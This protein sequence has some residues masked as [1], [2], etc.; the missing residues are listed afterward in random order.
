MAQ[1]RDGSSGRG[2]DRERGRGAR[3]RQ[4]APGGSR[5]GRSSAGRAAGSP[6]SRHS[7]RAT[8]RT[9]S[10]R[11]QAPRSQSGRGSSSRS[12]RPARGASSARPSGG[13]PR[14]GRGTR[15]SRPNYGL[16]RLG[17]GLLALLLLA[18][19]VVGVLL[20]ALKLRDVVRSQN[21]AQAASE[22]TTVYAEPTTCAGGELETALSAPSSV[23]AGQEVVIKATI[24]NN[25]TQ[26]CVVDGGSTALTAVITSGDTQVWTSTQCT[27]GPTSRPLLIDAGATSETTLTWDGRVN[28]TVCPTVSPTPTEAAG[29]VPS[30]SAKATEPAT[31]SSAE[32]TATATEQAGAEPSLDPSAGAEASATATA[33]EEPGSGEVAEAGTYEVH[34]ELGGQSVTDGSTFTI[35]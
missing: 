22:V 16:R 9:A 15:G 11:A 5:G 10:S 33:S 2:S 14:G 7:G 26:P 1:G 29:S 30:A 17:F 19:V 8:G 18:G 25:G 3:G 27:V 21:E 6:A 13:G 20:G 35:G 34:L 23:S 24:K 31:E 32:P 12:T 28:R 4:S